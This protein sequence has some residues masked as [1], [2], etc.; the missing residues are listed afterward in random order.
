MEVAPLAQVI[1]STVWGVSDEDYLIKL[2][3]TRAVPER[4]LICEGNHQVPKMHFNARNEDRM[5]QDDRG[6]YPLG[7]GDGKDS[8]SVC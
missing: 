8:G 7:R 2:P 4:K 1:V 5:V 6:C 3:V